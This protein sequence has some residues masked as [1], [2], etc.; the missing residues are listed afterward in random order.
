LKFK[1]LL[2]L[3]LSVF[4]QLTFSLE[5][6][7]KTDE[8]ESFFSSNFGD[9]GESLED[10]ADQNKQGVFVFFH[11]EECPFCEKMKQTVLNK[12]GVVDYFGKN[13]LT[14]LADVNSDVE[15][16]NFNGEEMTGKVFAQKYNKIGA[17]PVLA[18]FDLKGK[19]I[20]TRTGFVPKDEFLLLAKF[21]AEKAYLKQS[22]MRYK[23]QQKRKN[24][25][26]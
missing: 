20:T 25:G 11:M 14:L 4:S 10:A 13:F 26:S 16:V 9:Y 12:P 1:L 18:F 22:F 6:N 8:K 15:I 2:F 17:T 5:N 21:V 23:Y 7:E 19:K 24:K 3:T